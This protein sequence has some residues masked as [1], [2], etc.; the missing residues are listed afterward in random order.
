M[1]ERIR[2]LNEAHF[3]WIVSLRRTIHQNPELSFQEKETADFVHRTLR[4]MGLEPRTMAQTGVVV[5]IT[6]NLPGPTVALRADMDALPILESTGLPFTSRNDGVMHACGHD[7]HTASLLGVAR[8]LIDMKEHLRGTIRLV[9]QPGEERIPGGAQAMIAEGAL[10]AFGDVPAPICIIGQHVDPRMPSGIVGTR[11]GPLMGSADELYLTIHGEGGHAAD[12]HKLRGDVVIAQAHVLTALQTIVSRNCPPDVPSVLSFGKVIADGA[13]NIIP[14][15]VY[16]E[17]TFRSTDEVWRQR[18][19][20]LI[21]RTVEQTATALGTTADL[22]ILLGYPALVND[23]NLADRWMHVASGFLGELQVR[24]LPIWL[25]AEDFAYYGE[26]IPALF[27]LLGVRNESVG[28][29]YALHTPQFTIDE[30]VL[31][32]APGLMVHSALSITDS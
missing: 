4:E 8:I 6:G 24:E 2:A 29:I 31:L 1:I 30:D 26:K 23:T 9:F 14:E 3:D 16:I 19:H 18:A 21:H 27:Y 22:N 32:F 25:A 5:D 17:G 11:G 15:S 10:D 20:E 12:P 7:A 28:S 13:T